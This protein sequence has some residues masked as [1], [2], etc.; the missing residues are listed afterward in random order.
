[1]WDGRA[2]KYMHER[3]IHNVLPQGRTLQK[4]GSNPTNPLCKSHPGQITTIKDLTVF[5]PWSNHYN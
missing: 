4:G 3:T 1:M 2:C 5:T